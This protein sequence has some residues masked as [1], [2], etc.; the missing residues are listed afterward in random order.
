MDVVCASSCQLFNPWNNVLIL[1]VFPLLSV[2]LG[3]VDS[4]DI[5]KVMT[6][7]TSSHCI[8]REC[9]DKTVEETSF[10]FDFRNIYILLNFVVEN[11]K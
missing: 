11:K 9:F 4:K 5:E 2:R 10:L 1:T 3:P 7:S 8:A 6:L